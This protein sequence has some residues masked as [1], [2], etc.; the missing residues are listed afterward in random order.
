M[1]L[2][3]LSNLIYQLFLILITN[4]IKL[5]S[6]YNDCGSVNPSYIF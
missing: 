1:F 2:I 3:H 5:L 4:F 6:F